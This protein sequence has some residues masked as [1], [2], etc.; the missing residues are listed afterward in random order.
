MLSEAA[1]T[2]STTEW[3]VDPPQPG[4]T[5]IIMPVFNRARFIPQAFESVASQRLTDWELIVVDDGST[6]DTAGLVTELAKSMPQPVRYI[7]QENRGAY[8]ARN[9]GV[10]AARGE[11]IAFY[12]SDDYWLPHHLARCVGALQAHPALDWTYGACRLLDFET[13]R[14]LEPS[15]F[16][17]DGMPRP[18][19]R[20][21]ARAEGE[22]RVIADSGAVRC[23]ILHGLFCGLQNS[24]LRRRV[25]TGRRFWEQFKVVDDQL[26]VIRVLLAGG[27]FAYFD[28][29]HVNYHVHDQNSSGSSA[30]ISQAHS[31]A[32]LD[33][34]V[35]GFTYLSQ[36][37]TLAPSQTRALRRRLSREYFWHLG[38]VS[39]WQHGKRR[40]A[41]EAFKKAL[42]LWPW[43]A[44]YWKTYLVARA[45]VLVANQ[46]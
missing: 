42:R 28:D 30:A 24:V 22:L 10:D 33:E 19:L 17:V 14:L 21:R 31:F 36:Q 26:F 44:R 5:S 16:Y 3:P 32:V 2:S 35:R 38:Y 29:V 1:P 15:S 7:R 4:L 20:L 43:D 23:M 25:F 45:R 39:L 40:E 41:L 34:Q 37:V 27:R 11:Y 46:R 13:R 18:F 9:T 6:D 8:G 12:D